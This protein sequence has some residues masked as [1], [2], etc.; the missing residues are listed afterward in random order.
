MHFQGGLSSVLNW[1]STGNWFE[2]KVAGANDRVIFNT[3]PF[4]GQ[5]VWG[6]PWADV[7]DLTILR[8]GWKFGA[9]SL[10]VGNDLV[11]GDYQHPEQMAGYH[12][13]SLTFDWDGSNLP[14]GTAP[15]Q[16]TG[17]LNVAGNTIIGKSAGSEGT[18]TL[19]NCGT[20][21][22]LVSNNVFVG[23]NGNGTLNLVNASVQYTNLGIGMGAGSVGTMVVN[24]AASTSY[25]RS[26][27]APFVGISNP[28]PQ[29]T[30]GGVGSGTLTMKNGATTI[31]QMDFGSGRLIS[32]MGVVSL[33]ALAGS[34]GT[35]EL[36][37]N[38]S[39]NAFAV[40]V[41]TQGQG[42]LRMDH[43]TL[44]VARPYSNRP[45]D[46]AGMVRVGADSKIE[47]D[48]E[49]TLN[50]D[51]GLSLG[52]GATLTVAGGAFV[53]APNFRVEGG[54]A[55]F[56][57]NLTG[58]M[59]TDALIALPGGSDFSTL[60][61]MD[62]ASGLFRSSLKTGEQGVVT[63]ATGGSIT[64]GYP[65]FPALPG[66][67]Q[68]ASGGT[69]GGRGLFE[70]DIDVAGG[71]VSPGFS[72]GILSVDGDFTMTDGALILEID[73]L[74]VGSGY[75]VLNVTGNLN[76]SGGLIMLIS[77]NGFVPPPG[78]VFQFLNASHL[79]IGPGVT[80]FNA[81]G[82]GFVFDPGTGSGGVTPV[83]EPATWCALGL[84]VGLLR[85]RRTK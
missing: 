26:L 36:M 52:P 27:E 46:G 69:L 25:R 79:S 59:G 44:T 13:A 81:V 53:S 20:N 68:V 62:N 16:Y 4:D 32:S 38:A 83:P 2:G 31:G 37:S 61:L 72:P 76:V 21:P 64:V 33:G 15:F 5:W 67:I 80:V 82:G 50:T 41:G 10:N 34:Q 35:F 45:I 48:H 63:L 1:Y 84:G 42:T 57:G 19:T 8:G 75:D 22:S 49:S 43:G 12:T 9:A 23:A 6:Y 54:N 17:N 51:V 29:V 56:R 58:V 47:M 28:I 71:T 40:N 3:L 77:P 74:T 11:V 39:A 24:G 55:T 70:A 65:S 78:A 60:T 7:K 66:H 73:G 85:R 18:I 14:N 30:I